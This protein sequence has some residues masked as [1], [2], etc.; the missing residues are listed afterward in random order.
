MTETIT[1]PVIVVNNYRVLFGRGVI[2]SQTGPFDASTPPATRL[3]AL[4][5]PPPTIYQ[6]SV[7]WLFT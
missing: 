5:A 4:L 7:D 1:S 3:L 6:L 2:A